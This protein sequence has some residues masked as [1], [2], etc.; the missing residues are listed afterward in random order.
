[1]V[2]ESPQKSSTSEEEKKTDGFSSSALK[3]L[4]YNFIKSGTELSEV[5]DY[6]DRKLIVEIYETFPLFLCHDGH[7]FL[8]L[9]FTQEAWKAL[10]EEVKIEKVDLS[11]MIHHRL[12]IGKMQL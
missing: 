10:Q 4:A 2:E 12:A 7:F 5:F 1:M 3:N 6:S 11:D 8:Q 9:V